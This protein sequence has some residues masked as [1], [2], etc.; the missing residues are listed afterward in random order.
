VIGAA[1]ELHYA[2]TLLFDLDPNA[3]YALCVAGLERLSR[4]YGAAPA[5]WAAWEDA[6][7]LDRVFEE[8]S[9]SES[10]QD[11]LRQEL[12][13]NRHLRLPK[14]VGQRLGCVAGEGL[15]EGDELFD[16]SGLAWKHGVERALSGWL[17]LNAWMK[18]LDLD[19]R[20]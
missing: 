4:A 13:K 18:G 7:R 1:A 9:L 6:Q 2:S 5:E 11:R 10:Q 12:L 16:G 3:A 14:L 19:P 8:L 20:S 15:A 17:H